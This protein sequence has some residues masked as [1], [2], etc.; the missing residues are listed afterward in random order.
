MAPTTKKTSR[1]TISKSN[2]KKVAVQAPVK[3]AVHYTAAYLIDPQH[4][5]TVNVIGC[6]G[7]GSQVINTLGRMHSALKALGHPGL[8]VRAIDPDKVTDANAAR[9]LF[10]PADVDGYKCTILVGRINRFF[11]TDWE[12]FPLTYTAKSE[13]KAANI[14]I[15]C[16]DSGKARKEIKM[17]LMAAVAA[18]EPKRATPLG[19]VTNYAYIRERAEP[20]EI[21]YYWMDYGNMRDR[22]QMVIGT[23]QKIKQPTGSE[24]IC[25]DTLPSIDK[26]HPDIFRDRKG[27]D[28][29]PSCSLA[30]AIGRQDLL[31]NTNLANKGLEILWK[32][33]HE[34]H[35]KYHGVYVNQETMSDNGI[36]IR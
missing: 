13:I 19:R 3:E 30:E 23:L 14:T 27:S 6:G 29:G 33:F 34:A 12:A 26:L 22:G 2:N 25:R 10:S 24:Y 32:L 15:S 17:H 7:T 9:Q 21:P 35:I 8:F 18:I 20:Y 16:V 31:I 1:T 11:G 28:Q 5:V 4:P 36:R